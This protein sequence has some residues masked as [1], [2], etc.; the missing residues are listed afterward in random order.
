MKN[1]SSILIAD[2]N[3]KQVYQI[4]AELFAIVENNMIIKKSESL[5]QLVTEIKNN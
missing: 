2:Y 5:N 1:T 3:G 4:S